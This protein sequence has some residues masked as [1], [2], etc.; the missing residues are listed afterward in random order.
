MVMILFIHKRWHGNYCIITECAGGVF[1]CVLKI[2]YHCSLHTVFPGNSELAEEHRWFSLYK[3]KIRCPWYYSQLAQI[4]FKTQF[5]K[6]PKNFISS[7]SLTE[8]FRNCAQSMTVTLQCSVQNFRRICW[9]N[10]VD[11]WVFVTDSSRLYLSSQVPGVSSSS[12]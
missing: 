5:L 9:K 10:L 11:V 2:Q 8:S 7:L 1:P 4:H 6:N 3:I 12:S